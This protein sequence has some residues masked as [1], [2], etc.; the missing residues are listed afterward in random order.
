MSGPRPNPV[1]LED[2][3]N[4]PIVAE[5]QDIRRRSQHESTKSSKE[6]PATPSDRLA[7]PELIG[8]MDVGSMAQLLLKTPDDRVTWDHDINATNSSA[9]TYV[10]PIDRRKRARSSSPMSSP[11]HVSSHFAPNPATVDQKT[12]PGLDLWSGYVGAD[13]HTP[14]GPQNPLFAHLMGNASSPQGASADNSVSRDGTL[15]RSTSC[16][17]HFPKR[18]KTG[19]FEDHA[20]NDLFSESIKAAPSK[21]SRVS[22]LLDG[23][24]VKGASQRISSL[25]NGPSSSSPVPRSK[26]WSETGKSS[27]LAPKVLDVPEN[28]HIAASPRRPEIQC[29]EMDA[30]TGSQKSESASSDYGDFDDDVFDESLLTAIDSNQTMHQITSSPSKKR[31]LEPKPTKPSFNA[32]C[33]PIAPAKSKPVSPTTLEEEGDEFADSDDDIFA[34]D[35]EALVSKYDEQTVPARVGDPVTPRRKTPTK[36]NGPGGQALEGMVDPCD[37]YG[38]DEYGDDDGFDDTDFA[39]AEA[40]AIQSQQNSASSFPP[41][42]TKYP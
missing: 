32:Q 38:D 36:R 26:G 8:M 10:A 25:S 30:N 2:K 39:L 6:P 7:L 35:L 14:K 19:V 37:E 16:G 28:S 40:S 29:Q 21:L 41:V 18:R 5:G 12:G 4:T 1:D 11:A 42:R 3:E 15:R 31:N 17:T 13:K 23:I 33:S 9:S 24:T 22:A 34:A 20:A 27:P